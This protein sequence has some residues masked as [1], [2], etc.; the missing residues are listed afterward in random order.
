[1]SFQDAIATLPGTSGFV[2]REYENAM[3]R[4]FYVLKEE[5]DKAANTFADLKTRSPQEIEEFL[6]D[7]KNVARV[8]MSKSVNK[9]AD[10]LSKLRK[11]MEQV[12]NSDM[13]ADEKRDR[14]KELKESESN[15][16]KNIDVKALR[17]MGKI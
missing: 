17:E 11:Y 3:K 5:V 12:R 2:S 7:E 16:M 15:M 4:D 14:I 8:G 13:P 1:M 6:K 10:Q 9:I